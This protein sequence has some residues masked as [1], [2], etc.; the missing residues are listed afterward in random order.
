MRRGTAAIGAALL[1]LLVVVACQ[2]VKRPS[3]GGAGNGF[4]ACAAPSTGTM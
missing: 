4:D 1:V 3:N 2:P